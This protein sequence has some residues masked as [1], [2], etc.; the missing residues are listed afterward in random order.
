MSQQSLSYFLAR[1]DK[2]YTAADLRKGVKRLNKS[3]AAR[4]S[5]QDFLATLMTQR[6]CRLASK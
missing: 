5:H 6:L 3:L 4:G 1:R 2:T